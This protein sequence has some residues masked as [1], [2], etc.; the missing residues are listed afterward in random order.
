MKALFAIFI[1]AT[2]PPEAYYLPPIRS[3]AFGP[4]SLSFKSKSAKSKNLRHFRSSMRF[5]K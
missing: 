2:K 5:G 3:E 4:H 1:E